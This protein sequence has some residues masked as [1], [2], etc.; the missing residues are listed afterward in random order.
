ME[1]S[2]F[3][4]CTN[5]VWVVGVVGVAGV[6]C[7]YIDARADGSCYPDASILSSRRGLKYIRTFL[8]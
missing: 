1:R 7:D 3:I 6:D 4:E 2:C 8:G 5:V